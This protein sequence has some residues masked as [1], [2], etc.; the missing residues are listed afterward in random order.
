[1]VGQE[2]EEEIMTNTI[3]TRNSLIDGI[4]RT[5]CTLTMPLPIR[6]L[7]EVEVARH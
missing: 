2:E 7:V 6:M 1:M 5:V 3:L 4:D